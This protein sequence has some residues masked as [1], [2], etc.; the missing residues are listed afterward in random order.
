M[1]AKVLGLMVKEK[2]VRPKMRHHMGTLYLYVYI[3]IYIK[4]LCHSFIKFSQI[5]K[6]S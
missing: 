4:T 2:Y 1:Q 6:E 5:T 3:Y